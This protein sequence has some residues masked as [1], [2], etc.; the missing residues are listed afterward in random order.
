MKLEDISLDHIDTE[1]VAQ[2]V[3]NAAEDARKPKNFTELAALIREGAKTVKRYSMQWLIRNPDGTLMGCA[4]GAASYAL[5]GLPEWDRL[6]TF[7]LRQNIGFEL[8]A[9]QISITEPWEWSDTAE[10]IITNLTFR[11]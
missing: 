2:H 11:S 7:Q 8:L 1:K 10:T 3:I 9:K 4:L 5:H 6:T